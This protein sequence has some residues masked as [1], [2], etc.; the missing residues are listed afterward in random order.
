MLTRL[1]RA[2]FTAGNVAAR[3]RPV[4]A[5]VLAPR[6]GALLRIDGIDDDGAL[7]FARAELARRIY[8]DVV[9]QATVAGAVAGTVTVPA[10]GRS[11]AVLRISDAASVL[12]ILAWTDGASG[13]GYD[14]ALT[15]LVPGRTAQTWPEFTVDV[16]LAELDAA[17][18][19]PGAPAA[20]GHTAYLTQA[21]LVEILGERT[22]QVLAPSDAAADGI[23]AERVQEAIDD[24]AGEMD[25][26]IRHRYRVPL[27]TV[28]GF[29]VRA[30]ARLVH[31]ALAD[32]RTSSDL[33][34]ERA[35]AAR[36]L[37]RRLGAGEIHLEAP[38]PDGTGAARTG[39]G[40][41][42]LTLPG[43]ARQFGRDQTAGIV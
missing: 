1:A 8:T 13:T 34:R 42:I 36:S 30:A 6:T 41:V 16:S 32:G 11:A 3:A 28:P 29:L 43:G 2:T 14:P 23:D 25:A 35:T 21:R 22:V 26:T 4:P 37:L 10:G 5:W 15:W 27:T 24:V 39:V 33:I 38:Q 31:D 9:F 7:R 12:P 40:R 18:A 19:T 20:T 17:G